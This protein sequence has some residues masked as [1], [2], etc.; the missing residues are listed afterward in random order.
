MRKL[1]AGF[2]EW[3]KPLVTQYLLFEISIRDES[4]RKQDAR[5]LLG[6][7]LS[8][9]VKMKQA[10]MKGKRGHT[11][12]S[13]FNSEVNVLGVIIQPMEFF[14]GRKLGEISKRSIWKG[15]KDRETKRNSKAKK[16]TKVGALVLKSS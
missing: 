14:N 9:S 2:I 5:S 1:V 16:L 10:N 7:N 15:K 12:Q 8:N 11:K 6:K 13:Q 4:K 3:L